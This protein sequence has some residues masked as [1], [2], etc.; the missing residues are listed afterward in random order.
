MILL[1]KRDIFRSKNNR[2]IS[3]IFLVVI[4]FT[5]LYFGLRSRTN[6]DVLETAH[7]RQGCE[8]SRYMTLGSDGMSYSLNN[9]EL[10]ELTDSEIEALGS[11]TVIA[12]LPNIKPGVYLIETRYLAEYDTSSDNTNIMHLS[13]AGGRENSYELNSPELWNHK[14]IN[15]TLMWVSDFRGTTKENDNNEVYNAE[16]HFNIKKHGALHISS[17]VIKDYKPAILGVLLLELFIYLLCLYY[18]NVFCK[19]DTEYKVYFALLVSLL[20]FSSML[21]LVWHKSSIPGHD[22]WFHNH[23]ITS[24]ASE[25]MNGHF[26]VI[27]QPDAWWGYGYIASIMYGKILLYVPCLLHLLGMPIS[28]AYTVYV[29]MINGITIGLSYY[30]FKG[31]FKQ[32]NLALI[33]TAI[34]TLASYRI[35]CLYFRA[36]L[37]EYSA[38]AF[39]PLLIYGLYRMYSIDEKIGL[40]DMLP[41]IVAV[42]GLIETHILTVEMTIPFIISFAI[43]HYKKT[44]KR[45]IPILQSLG[46]VV[47]GNIFFLV[48][49]I[50]QYTNGL[51]S[52]ANT[53]SE[54]I[55]ESGTYLP[56]VLSIFMTNEGMNMY[57]TMEHEMPMTIGGVL[58]V[59]IVITCLAFIIDR[60]KNK[61]KKI[62]IEC[63][64]YGIICIWLSTIYFPWNLFAGK[65]S[66][67]FKIFT[68]IQFPW[69]YLGLAS[70]FLT[71][72]TIYALKVLGNKEIQTKYFSGYIN[73]YAVLLVLSVIITGDFY[74]RYMNNTMTAFYCTQ[75]GN[76]LMDVLYLP[77]GMNDEI[78]YDNSVLVSGGSAQVKSTGTDERGYRTFSVVGGLEN[79]TVNLP[80]AYYDF[81][82][83]VN[84]DTG[85]VVPSF[86]GDNKRISFVVNQN[87]RYTIRVEHHPKISWIISIIVSLLTWILIG[88]V[89]KKESKEALNGPNS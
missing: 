30:S 88:I 1:M 81:L 87:E 10:S 32:K 85:Q 57:G 4:L 80:V 37:G 65:E 77:E 18:I 34:Y 60:E 16:M 19:K 20:V 2:I 75:A 25:I 51:K 9:D 21:A 56:Q 55:L 64:I 41:M 35:V 46:I 71:V 42:S 50:D 31:I 22:F 48:P 17:V 6:I 40:R 36:A 73:L 8:L 72:S 89:I 68:S 27:Y 43:I 24:M 84:V 69:R 5:C 44:I 74:T 47:L 54:N 26:P 29:V 82:S 78:L 76:I 86:S 49:F 83:V 15:K 52:T 28:N 11:S 59:S 14:S 7:I 53:Y 3:I 12:T 38:M 13:I 45:I 67:F 33:G 39:L 79:S 66:T 61:E 23:R 70:V 58:V 62:A 63:F